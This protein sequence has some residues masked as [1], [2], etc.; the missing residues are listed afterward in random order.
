MQD[1]LRKLK[2]SKLIKGVRSMY[3]NY[4]YGILYEKGEIDFWKKNIKQKLSFGV[5]KG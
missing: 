5:K 4:F 3:I 2:L 1:T